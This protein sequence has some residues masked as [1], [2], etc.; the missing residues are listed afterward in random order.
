MN[1]KKLIAQKSLNNEQNREKPHKNISPFNKKEQLFLR[2]LSGLCGIL[3]YA[4]F[5]TQKVR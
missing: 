4:V 3:A 5:K 2:H 1:L